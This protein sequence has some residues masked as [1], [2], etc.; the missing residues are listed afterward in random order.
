MVAQALSILAFIQERK[1]YYT[2]PI[3]ALVSEKFF[4]AIKVFGSKNVGMV[5]GDVSLNAHAPIIF[6]TA[7][8]LAIDAVRNAVPRNSAIIMDE[9]HYYGD[10]ERGWAWQTPLL[11]LPNAQFLL[12]SA[13]LGDTQRFA[14]TLTDNTTRDVSIIDNT[15][16]PIPLRYQYEVTPITQCVENLIDTHNVPIYIV[17]FSQRRSMEVGAT[18]VNF[19]VSTRAQRDLIKEEIKDFPFTTAFGKILRRLLLGGVGVHH[20]GMLPRYRRLVEKLSQKGLLPV[21]C[22][23]DTLGV[24]IN[25]PIHTV[26]FTSLSKFDGVKERHLRAREFHQIAGRAGRSGFD[27][28]GLV[29]ALA[30]E[31]EIENKQQEEKNKN[32]TAKKKKK[33][34]KKKAPE[35]FVSWSEDT[36]N[37]LINTP[38][39]TL[40][41][42]LQ[43]NHTLV[44]AACERGGD[45]E[46]YLTSMIE[47]SSQTDKQKEQLLDKLH[48]ILGTLIGTKIIETSTITNDDGEQEVDYFLAHDIPDNFRL[49]EPLS[50]FFIAVL[51]LLDPDSETYNA[52]VLSALESILENPRPIL[53]AQ[54]KEAKTAAMDEMKTDG[55]DYD[56]RMERLEEITY[57][58]PLK[59]LLDEA[60]AQY[61]QDVPWAADYELSPKSVVRDM[62]ETASTFTTYIS[63]YHL[64]QSEGILLRY[65]SDTY[66]GLLRT[67]PPSAR[68]Q[69]LDDVISWLRIVIRGTDSSLLDEWNTLHLM[70][71]GDTQ[72]GSN[73]K[74]YSS[75]EST[76]SAIA[77]PSLN[78]DNSSLT[79]EDLKG[80]ELLIRNSLIHRV[81][82]IA[83]DRPDILGELDSDWNIS[84][85]QWDDILE[86]IYNEHE[87]ILTDTQARSRNYFILDKTLQS[88]GLWKVRQI[89]D[90]IEGDNDWSISGIIDLQ[91]SLDEARVV[92]TQYEVRHTA[93][94]T[95]DISAH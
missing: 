94:S 3:K 13:T 30:P 53:R 66:R 95:I 85:R 75:A 54:E 77:V 25:V 29:V 50:P 76:E 33:I 32:S 64:Q 22:G 63:R 37:K 14:K 52:D 6:C 79:P 20:A 58:Q 1:V 81:E 48:E 86:D 23:T 51:T 92:F 45:V 84:A 9:F 11:T 2:A 15:E 16:R 46:E 34:V 24:G 18:L 69:E 67:L 78:S 19:G 47:R 89:L 31:F 59:N 57:P 62:L 41:P 38:S 35:N 42:Y 82:L 93:N 27:N 90:D 61:E 83:L 60:F 40:R 28:E 56:T 68:T 72:A 26:L 71:E 49:A 7:E 80:L 5:T 70:Q 21:I 44:L 4:D 88:Q 8:I 36:F 65:L 12:M 10:R 91:Q 55:V 74:Q 17:S 73:A 43:I 87:E 39:E